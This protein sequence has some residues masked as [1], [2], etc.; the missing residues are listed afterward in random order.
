MAVVS[1]GLPATGGPIARWRERVFRSAPADRGEVVLR[2][3]RIYILPTRRGLAFIATIAT[4]IVTSLNYGLALGFLVAFALAGLCAA[5]LLHTFRNLAGLRVRPGAAGETFAGGSI[6]FT[7]HLDGDG[8]ERCGIVVETRDGT[9]APLDVAGDANAQAVVEVAAPR[10][11]RVALGRVTLS[12][13]FP[14]GLWRGWA[15]VHFPAEGLAYPAPEAGAPPL[16]APQGVSDAPG[17]LRHDDGDLAGLRGYQHGD[18][19]QRVAWKSVA[20]GAGWYTKA[21]EGGGGDAGEVVLDF[22]ALP[23]SL[24][25]ERRLERLCAWVLACE[26][27]A[28]PCAV[29]LPQRRVA[30]GMGREHRREALTALA[31]H[32]LP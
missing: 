8:R 23:A 24:D 22:A 4:M 9:P 5:A 17:S 25:A 15:Y 19:L 13:D 10:R 16:P 28:R 31:L 26:R 20:R 11:G 29:V 6:P 32:G 30:A 7:L 12:S 27:A 18:P 14:L 21:F 2:H 1:Q 3:S